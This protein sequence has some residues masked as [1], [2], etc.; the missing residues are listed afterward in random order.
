MPVGAG[1]P[2]NRDARVQPVPGAVPVAQLR[3]GTVDAGARPLHCRRDEPEVPG[4][5]LRVARL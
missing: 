4:T 1:Q 3:G 2:A 5:D